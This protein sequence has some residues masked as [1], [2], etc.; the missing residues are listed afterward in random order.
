MLIEPT[1]SH[2]YKEKKERK[3]TSIHFYKDNTGAT[4]NI[5]GKRKN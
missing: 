4:E 5:N 3:K 1:E 2:K